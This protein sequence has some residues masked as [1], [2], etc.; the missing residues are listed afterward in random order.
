MNIL[1]QNL[2]KT[3]KGT[4]EKEELSL[5]PSTTD[6]LLIFVDAKILIKIVFEVENEIGDLMEIS[7]NMKNSL[8]KS[9]RQAI[10]NIIIPFQSISTQNDHSRREYVIAKRRGAVPHLHLNFDIRLA[11]CS[12]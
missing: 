4:A 8:K 11:C 12:L 10:M 6:S 2:V 5:E 7:L 3:I 1:F 9:M